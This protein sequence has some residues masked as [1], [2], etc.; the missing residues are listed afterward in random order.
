MA[1]RREQV[2][3]VCALLS[4]LGGFF[5]SCA[6]RMAAPAG[7]MEGPLMVLL[8]LVAVGPALASAAFGLM[9]R[10]SAMGVPRETLARSSAVA[11][12]LCGLAGL[13]CLVGLAFTF[14]V[15]IDAQRPMDLGLSVS[16]GGLVLSVVG[17]VGTFLGFVTQVGIARRSAAVSRGVGRM[18]VAAAVCTLVLLGISVLY[19]LIVE[20]TTPTYGYGPYGGYQHYPDHSGFAVVMLGILMPLAFGV[21]L[22]LYHRLLAAGRRAVNSEAAGRY[23]D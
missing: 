2:A 1:F 8:L 12:L 19:T 13:A 22:I 7:R 23:D 18:A 3:L 21:V 10:I 11:S 15:S 16:L 4:I 20:A 6:G 9:A 5:I 17:A 14:L